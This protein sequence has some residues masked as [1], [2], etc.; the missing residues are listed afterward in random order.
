MSDFPTLAG[1]PV[2]LENCWTFILH[3]P[4]VFE[5]FV[6]FF[7]K[8]LLQ[9]YLEL[10]PSSEE[11]ED[12]L[13]QFSEVSRLTS[14][15]QFEHWL[16]TNNDDYDSFMERMRVTISMKKFCHRIDSYKD[17]K[18]RFEA[19][20]HQFDYFVLSRLL[21]V[22]Q[23]MAQIACKQIKEQ[24]KSLQEIFQIYF[25]SQS[26]RLKGWKETFLR[27]DLPDELQ[28]LLITQPRN[29][30]NHLFNHIIDQPLKANQGWYLVYIHQFISMQ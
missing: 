13:N 27:A 4:K 20:K 21:F 25:V 26:V 16:E 6:Y 3:Q 24:Q 18:A 28:S 8:Q 19:R 11:V 2:T 17:I 14:A 5:E 10:S 15:E 7:L 9:L 22:D 1:Q 29:S 12:Y 30:V 23:A